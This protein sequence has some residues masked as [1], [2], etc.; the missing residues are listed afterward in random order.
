MNAILTK[1][2][3]LTSLLRRRRAR[4]R[5]S[6]RWS[7]HAPRRAQPVRLS[8]GR[9]P[10]SDPSRALEPPRGAPRQEAAQARS[11]GEPAARAARFPGDA[12]ALRDP[13]FCALHRRTVLLPVAVLAGD[14]RDDHDGQHPQARGAARATNC[15]SGWSAY[16]ISGHA[17]T[18]ASRKA[19]TRAA[20]PPT[21]ARSRRPS[22]PGGPKYYDDNDWVGHRAR[23]ALQDRP[24]P[25]G[26]VDR[27]S[28]DEVRDGGLAGRAGTRM[29]SAGSRSRTRSK[30]PTATPSRRRRRPSSRCSST[31]STRTRNTSASP[32]R[33]TNGCAT[34]CC[35]RA[36]CTPITSTARAR[37]NRRCGA[38]TRAR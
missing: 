21:T 29:Q 15:T 27:G 3:A 13:R 34:A 25:G 14:G 4:R 12:A 16:L 23:P 35:C 1:R 8:G 2:L 26:P 22:G 24:Q 32:S 5:G 19:S 10:L 17:T 11:E 20:C 33:H 31:G 7:A 38:T 30:T 9:D 18:Q 6:I 36:G 28:A 37:S